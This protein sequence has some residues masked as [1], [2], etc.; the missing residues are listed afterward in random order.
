MNLTPHLLR[1][2]GGGDA[3]LVGVAGKVGDFDDLA[4]L[5][6]VGEQ[7]DVLLALQAGRLFLHLF[8]C[9]GFAP[10]RFFTVHL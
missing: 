2:G 5:V 3:Q 9:H 4:G 1:R 8:D 6:A 7:T 10:L